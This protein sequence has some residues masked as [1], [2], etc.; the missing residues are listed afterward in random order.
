MPCAA[1]R[2]RPRCRELDPMKTTFV[3]FHAQNL[4]LARMEAQLT[5]L[6]QHAA[7]D[8]VVLL[9]SDMLVVESLAPVFD[10]SYAVGVTHRE[11]EKEMPYNGG[12]YFVRKAR[13]A[14]AL[15]FFE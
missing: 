13:M 5:Y 4:M 7:T 10:G 14:E 6:R 2:S 11:D 9:D 3:V 8:N 15:R 1:R 12:I